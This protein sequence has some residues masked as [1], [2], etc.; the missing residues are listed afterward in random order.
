MK[1]RTASKMDL[2]DICLIFGSMESLKDLLQE[3]VEKFSMYFNLKG[4][5]I[6]TMDRKWK[7]LELGAH[8]GLS[9]D[10]VTKGTI[11]IE[12]SPIDQ[13]LLNGKTVL[14]ENA[15]ED[16]RI[17][18]PE[19][20]RKEGIHSVIF[21]P[22]MTKNH[23]LGVLRGYTG[24]K[25]S[26]TREELTQMEKLARQAA[27]AIENAAIKE[28]EKSLQVFSRTVNSSLDLSHVLE[29]AAKLAAEAMNVKACTIKLIDE[30][31]H[32]MVLRGSS[33]LSKS[34][35]EKSPLSIDDLPIDQEV[36]KG[37]IVYIP[38]VTKDLRFVM[39]ELAEKEGLISAL[40]VPLKAMDRV[41]GTMRVYTAT[42]YDFS[43]EERSYLMTLANQAAIAVNNAILHE[44][45]HTLFLV[46]SSLSK[47]LDM[48]QVF[49]TIVESATKA[50]NAQGC[51]LILW[52]PDTNA[53]SMEASYGMSKEFLNILKEEYVD[54]SSEILCGQQMIK[55]HLDMDFNKKCY[56]I[57]M[58]EGI[59]SF[60]NVPMLAKEHLTGIIQI[61]FAY[62][63]DF[64]PDEIEFVCALANE[65]AVAIEN[66]KLY[67]ALNKKYHH[68]V[69]DVFLWY[70]GTSR[71]MDY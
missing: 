50:M 65:A 19:N 5:L 3:I 48:H 33:G 8:C 59:H 43:S 54:S 39:P 64:T 55:C 6:R 22:L 2:C 44:R 45:L 26:F 25:R 28:R 52:Q 58:K 66:A 10:Y 68:L 40:C 21:L 13:E 42:E 51:A 24:E 46:S 57:A 16:P 53:F 14:I 36:M 63:R 20:V 1:K 69:E 35:I 60:V 7:T 56:S 37:Q 29:K 23:V 15:S 41:L 38:E 18:Y 4:A 71:G 12:K 67:E 11:V 70:D 9:E 49:T 34:F 32:R 62:A 61:F 27:T 17:Q 31:G 47:S 30:R